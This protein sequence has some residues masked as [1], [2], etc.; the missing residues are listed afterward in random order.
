MSTYISFHCSHLSSV[1]HKW[2]VLQTLL[3]ISQL[4]S[5]PWLVHSVKYSLH[6]WK[7][8]YNLVLFLFKII[9]ILHVPWMNSWLLRMAFKVVLYWPCLSRLYVKLCASGILNLLQCLRYATYF[10]SSQ[11]LC[12]LFFQLWKLFSPRL[13]LFQLIS[14]LSG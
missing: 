11:P 9:Q 5:C 7:P 6:F 2:P 14:S 13:M 3:I 12:I 1:H 10:L 4:Q 8:I